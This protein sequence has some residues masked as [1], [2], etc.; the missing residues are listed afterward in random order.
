MTVQEERNIYFNPYKYLPYQRNFILIDSERTIGKTYSIQKF[1]I[2]KALKKHE[3]FIYIVRTQKEKSQKV[4]A[5]AFSKVLIEQFPDYIFRFSG[6][7]CYYDVDGDKSNLELIGI[8]VA[9]SE[10][11]ST[12]RINYP[13]IKWGLFDEYILDTKR[14][15]EYITG[16]NEPNLLLKLYHTIDREEDY[17]TLFMCAN[18]IQFYNPYHTHKAF[19]IPNTELNQIYL[20]DN[21]LYSHVEASKELKTKKSKSKF[22][23]MIDNTE[24]G[25]Y[26]INGVFVDDNE[27]F[28]EKRSS[29]A[30]LKMVFDSANTTFGVWYDTNKGLAYIDDKYNKNFP[31]WFTFDPLNITEGKTFAGDRKIYL[32]KWLGNMYKRGWIRWKNMEIKTKSLESILKML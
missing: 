24:Y 9:L 10:A 15:S 27:S 6:N 23:N 14:T 13:R 21:V 32:C 12:K 26:A 1:L 31:Y 18:T 29:G 30:N 19:N 20:G 17:L 5:D 8:C 7:K 16:F 3:R 4:F 25:H 2:N 28:I 22:L 11:N